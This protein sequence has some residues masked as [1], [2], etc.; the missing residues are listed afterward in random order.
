M[1]RVPCVCVVLCMFL[2]CVLS[3]RT[4]CK[5]DGA[6]AGG[7]SCAPLLAATL[8]VHPQSIFAEEREGFLRADL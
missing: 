8:R 4:L 3:V 7:H 5:E 2:T 6:E 1:E